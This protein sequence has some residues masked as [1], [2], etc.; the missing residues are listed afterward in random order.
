MLMSER[1]ALR[2]F[3]QFKAVILNALFS[4]CKLSKIVWKFSIKQQ[5]FHVLGYQNTLNHRLLDPFDDCK[6]EICLHYITF[7]IYSKPFS[8]GFFILNF[9][10]NPGVACG[11]EIVISFFETSRRIQIGAFVLVWPVLYQCSIH[12]ARI[13]FTR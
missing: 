4:I 1:A 7:Q 11:H 10:F 3:S 6:W 13:A 12:S 2:R 8:V 5:T 9:Y